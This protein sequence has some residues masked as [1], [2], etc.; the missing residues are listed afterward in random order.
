MVVVTLLK[1]DFSYQLLFRLQL[2]TLI[3]N[4]QAG[5]EYHH[6]LDCE[7][8]KELIL[9]HDVGAILTSFDIITSELDTSGDVIRSAINQYL[10]II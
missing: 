8:T 1:R 10:C 9:L 4:F 6:F 7:E 2:Q 3:G 5:W